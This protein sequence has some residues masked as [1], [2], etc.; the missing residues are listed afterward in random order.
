[1]RGRSRF[2]LYTVRHDTF[3]GVNTVNEASSDQQF[4]DIGALIP[5]ADGRGLTVA[6][7]FHVEGETKVAPRRAPKVVG[8]DNEA[9]LREAGY[10]AADI[11]RLRDKG[12]LG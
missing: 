3:G 9:V 2:Q 11:G 5:F 8:Q 6:S 10:S 4:Q 1:M 12:A 7:P